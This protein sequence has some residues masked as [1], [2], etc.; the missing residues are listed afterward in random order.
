MVND[1][2]NQGKVFYPKRTGDVQTKI[3]SAN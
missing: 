1:L 3:H 2:I